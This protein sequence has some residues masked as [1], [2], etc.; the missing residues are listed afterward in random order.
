MEVSSHALVL[1]R[2][3]GVVF[4][5]AVFTNLGRDHLDFHA[6]LDD[7]FAAKA[8]LFT[9]ERARRA[10]VNVDDAY[11][12]RLARRADDPGAHLLGHRRRRR[13]A[14]HRRGAEAAGSRFTVHGPDGLV[15]E[16]GVPLPGDFN[17]ANAL[18]AIAGARRGRLRPRRAGRGHRPRVPASPA[19]WSGSRPAR[20]SWSSSTTPTSPTPSS[21]RCARCAR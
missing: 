11:G 1:G 9:P 6:D 18:A 15:L 16:A 5:V 19:G 20:T 14:R 10:L 4:D 2:V 7:Y 12:R 3:D 17:V 8:T 13:L 21:P